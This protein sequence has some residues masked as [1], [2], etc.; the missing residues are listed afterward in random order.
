MGLGRDRT[1]YPW[2]CCQIRIC[3]QTLYQLR[4]AAQYQLGSEAL[5]QLFEWTIGSGDWSEEMF[6][7][8]AINC[9]DRFNSFVYGAILG[10]LLKS[11]IVKC[12]KMNM[13]ESFQNYFNDYLWIQDLKLGIIYSLDW[14]HS[15]KHF[16]HKCV[17]SYT[18]SLSNS[19]G[20]VL[21]GYIF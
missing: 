16:F 2:I 17:I 8:Y 11:L 19:D 14:L 9:A 3:S 10:E 13:Y 21:R 1:H 18:R 12:I 20:S 15:L 6:T 7:C 5:L 4:Y